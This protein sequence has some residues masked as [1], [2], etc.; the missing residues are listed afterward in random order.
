MTAAIVT[1]VRDFDAYE[2]YVSKNPFCGGMS[3]FPFDNRVDN[4]PVPV[5]YNR[6]LDG[7]DYSKAAWFVFC[8]EDFEFQ[9]DAAHLLERLDKNR[10]HGPVGAKCKGFAG[11]G[12]QVLYGNMTEINRDGSGEPWNPAGKISKAVE[13]EAFDC[14][15][16]IVHSSLVEKHGLRFDE[17]LLFDLYV[18]DFCASA[19]VACGIRSFVEPIECR[20]H[21]GSKATGRLR[22]HLP[23]LQKKYPCDCFVGTL[24][25][26]GTP[27][28]QKRLQDAVL[29]RAAR[30][31]VSIVLLTWNRAPFLEICL[32]EMFA[33]FSPD[34]D[35]EVILMDNSSSDSTPEIL[36][37]YSGEPSVRV[38]RNSKNLR[39]NAYKKLFSM[40]RGRIVIEVDDDILRFPAGFDKT[41][42]EYF[43]AFPDYG[44][45]ALNVVQ[46]EKTN[47]AKPDSS[48]YKDDVRG[49]R[50]VEEGPAGG[51]CTGFRRKY[52]RL[53]SPLLAFMSF[54]M[55]RP[56]DGV[57]SG[58]IG[59]IFRKRIGIVKNA[60]CLHA[61]GPAYAREYGLAGREKEKYMAGNLPEM[62]ARFE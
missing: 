46:N 13:V 9:E 5:L 16:L 53:V 4:T 32:R 26:F 37:K 7:W 30:P 50:I 58:I 23:Y 8:H 43:E 35:R 42:L 52:Y 19:K 40:A 54:S 55:A 6:F 57:L 10:L 1:A 20:H 15:C 62:A 17:N 60:V 47:G 29:K 25:Y 51:W 14:C 28:W 45:L 48:C 12:M 44:Y 38:V 21:S 36:S 61:V 3:F 22:R 34:V 39:L 2:K 56:E 33:A 18:E 31:D 11:F 24:T 59:K 41:M 27:S 49:D